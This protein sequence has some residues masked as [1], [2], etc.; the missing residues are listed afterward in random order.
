MRLYIIGNGFDIY[1]GIKSKYA[2]FKD[3]VENND[4]ELFNT[5]ENYFN[6]DELWSDFEET[7]AYINIDTIKD[8]A[9]NYLV[10]YGANDWSDSYH[11]DYQYEIQRVIDAVTVQL[12]EHFTNWIL[13]LT[14]PK[15]EK[16]SLDKKSKH[17]IFNYTATLEKVYN[18]DSQNIL[19]IHNKAMDSN[20]ILILGHS[21]APSEHETLSSNN[22]EDTDVRV[23]EGNEILDKYFADTYKN[24]ETIIQENQGFF[25]HLC[26]V[27]EIFI[28][29]HS[30][31]QVDISY[32]Q[33]IKKH[34]NKDATWTVSYYGADQKDKNRKRVLD[35]GVDESKIKMITLDELNKTVHNMPA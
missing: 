3:Y 24:T 16:L 17:L 35:L 11:H 21:R 12:K 7:L 6:S 26:D 9:E 33:E 34:V 25:E 19:Y 31:S 13:Q 20:S 30:I 22:D 5:L 4:K 23:A 29:G 1:H 15:N 18:I 8:N 2:D 10:S 28:L 32:F 14:I 27:N